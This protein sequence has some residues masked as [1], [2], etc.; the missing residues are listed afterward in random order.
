MKEIGPKGNSN[1]D[2]ERWI[3]TAIMLGVVVAYLYNTDSPGNLPKEV[4]EK[5]E[6]RF[7]KLKKDYRAYVDGGRKQDG[8][9]TGEEI[10]EL[11][12]IYVLLYAP[13]AERIQREH[14]IPASIVMAQAL[15]ESDKGTSDLAILANNHFGIKH[16]EHCK[17]K[18]SGKELK[19]CIQKT[20]D[21]DYDRF[22]KYESVEDCFKDYVRFLKK[23][24]YEAC[25]ACGVNYECWAEE[26]E[27]AGY[28]TN[29]EY[30]EMLIKLIKQYGLAELDRDEE[31]HLKPGDLKNLEK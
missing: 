16:H 7:D 15:I 24:N 12:D 4:K 29:P 28:A 1:N 6:V 25:F 2:R 30:A 27:K 21:E 11:V 5:I 23:K 18:W 22:K 26:L 17:P 19:C 9:I 20:D 31:Y 8:R 14:G 3:A 13:T 10:T